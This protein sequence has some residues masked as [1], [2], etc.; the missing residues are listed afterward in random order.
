MNDYIYLWVDQY[1]F[2]DEIDGECK[3]LFNNFGISLS[4]KYKVHVENEAA[5]PLE[6]HID[7][8]A[9]KIL[10]E[11]DEEGCFY[12]EC[13]TDLKVIVGQNGAGKSSIIELLKDIIAGNIQY[14]N[15]RFCLV[16]I[17]ESNSLK[18]F[19]KNVD[20]QSIVYNN[21]PIDPHAAL[22]RN[23]SNRVIF[24][25]A[26]FNDE[27]HL[28]H[29]DGGHQYISDIGTKFLLQQD[30]E[31]YNNN[32]DLYASTDRFYTH[33]IL[34]SK[35]Q[36]N[37]VGNF[38]SEGNLLKDIFRFP[39]KIIFNFSRGLIKN[40]LHSLLSIFDLEKQDHVQFENK[41]FKFYDR[42][43]DLNLKIRFTLLIAIFLK[44]KDHPANNSDQEISL[45]L[46]AN[47]ENL[48]LIC[49]ELK[50]YIAIP[51]PESTE[52][53]LYSLLS[54]HQKNTFED[55]Y[56]EFFVNQEKD[57]IIDLLDTIESVGSHTLLLEYRWNRPMSSGESCYLRFFSRL[58]DEI[59]SL[60]RYGDI[61]TQ[62]HAPILI[63]EVDLYLHPEWQ[64]AWF[65][66]FIKGIEL[67]Q[68]K[69][70]IE[71]KLQLIMTTHSPFMLTDLIS[72]NIARIYR[73][74]LYNRSVLNMT[75]NYMV[76]NIYDIL[77]E[78]FFLEGTM[79]LFIENKLKEILHRS[80]SLSEKDKF[81][82]DHIGDAL[83]RSLVLRKV[84]R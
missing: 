58:Y 33:A 18:Y 24:Y 45:E 31:N 13:L 79:G 19:A 46:P 3:Y 7:D 72:D 55:T 67:M 56:Y 38:F 28:E 57:A 15:L 1:R 32:A 73:K 53:K 27:W 51:Y 62:L 83:I 29:P 23:L 76:G 63:D 34:D 69:T 22:V 42:I 26:T 17:D 43:N 20:I 49:E 71:L 12:S 81:V 61:T 80:G 48:N 30:V 54:S 84:S 25:T 35:R 47:E 2:I 21:T 5:P 60:K 11:P 36:I 70:G 16:F 37:F 10:Y 14:D 74:D 41:W 59:L 8:S 40:G 75:D 52:R 68:L 78:G 66:R 77:K 9:S 64:R 82:I 39:D 65:S 44:Y 4:S 50:Q 6:I